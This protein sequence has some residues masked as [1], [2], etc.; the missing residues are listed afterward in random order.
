MRD[1]INRLSITMYLQA[2]PTSYLSHT[3]CCVC[4]DLV[5]TG[6]TYITAL[7]SPDAHDS[8]LDH[9]FSPRGP[10]GREGVWSRIEAVRYVNFYL[11]NRCV[12]EKPPQ[13]LP[14]LAAFRCVTRAGR[15]WSHRHA[16]GVHCGFVFL[17]TTT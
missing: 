12:R 3:Y 5:R 15:T 17:P 8:Y 10:G 7:Q 6:I 2:V 16:H 13:S 4:A 11:D 14:Q 9:K 1:I